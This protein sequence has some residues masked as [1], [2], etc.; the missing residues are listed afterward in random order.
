MSIP[1]NPIGNFRQE[2]ANLTRCPRCL[3]F[4]PIGYPGALSR[5]DNKTEICSNCGLVE[6]IRDM[7]HMA[8]EN[9]FEDWPVS[10]PMGAGDV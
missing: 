1:V 4:L 3:S 8:P 5:R 9:P 6:A 7:K 10:T 2:Y